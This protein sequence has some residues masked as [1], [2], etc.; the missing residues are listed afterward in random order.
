MALVSVDGR[1]EGAVQNVTSEAYLRELVRLVTELQKN[2]WSDWPAGT[3]VVVRHVNEGNSAKTKRS[4]ERPDIVFT[5]V[6]A[7]RSFQTTQVVKGKTLR[8][9]FL[10]TDQP[11]LDT[12]WPASANQRPTP[13]NI[14]IDGVSVACLTRELSSFELSGRTTGTTVRRESAMASHPSVVLRQE[15]VDSTGWEVT[16]AGTRRSIGEKDFQC[17]EVRKW[18]RFY[19]DGPND[20]IV[21]RYLCPGVPGHVAEERTELYKVVKGQRSAAPYQ[22]DHQK[23]VELSVPMAPSFGALGTY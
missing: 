15:T 14:S 10:I 16:S 12:A 11:G 19:H 18:L 9:D 23:T 3:R 6:E 2:P 1:D 20:A 22:I 4:R 21:T 17:L 7:D 13:A 5:V 8:H